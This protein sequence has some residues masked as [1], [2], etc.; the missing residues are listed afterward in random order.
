MILLVRVDEKLIHGQ[1]VVGWGSALEPDRY[2]VV[3]DAVAADDWERELVLSGVPE[4]VGGDVVTIRDAAADWQRWAEDDTRRIVLFEGLEAAL[5]LVEEGVSVEAVNVGGLRAR[6]GRKEFISYVQL[7]AAEQ[8]A[9]RR[10]CARGV[11][12]EARD[13]PGSRG[14]DLC[15]M[16]R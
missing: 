6:P 1:V 9:A 11:A 5:G 8:E 13:V 12:L 15:A 7:D 2:T 14:V 4:G 16:L 10:L 3:D